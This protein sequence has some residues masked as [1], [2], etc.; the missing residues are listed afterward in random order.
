MPPSRLTSPVIRTKNSL[1]T[2]SSTNRRTMSPVPTTRWVR[3]KYAEIC[4]L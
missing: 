2:S 3:A 4:V 1:P